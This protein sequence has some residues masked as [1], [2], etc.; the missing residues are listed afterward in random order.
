MYQPVDG[1]VNV[2]AVDQRLNADRRDKSRREACV[3]NRVAR[4]CALGS[5][6]LEEWNCIWD[7]ECQDSVS[8]TAD[9]PGAQVLYY[10][11]CESKRIAHGFFVLKLV[12]ALFIRSR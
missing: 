5:Y 11:G 7:A 9:P 1:L 2:S 4:S 12:E 8:D 3:Y 10:S 6:N